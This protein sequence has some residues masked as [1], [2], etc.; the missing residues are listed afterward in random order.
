MRRW[1]IRLLLT[2][3][4]YEALILL[5]SQ[6]VGAHYAD[7]AVRREGRNEQYQADYLRRLIGLVAKSD[8]VINAGST[9]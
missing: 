5:R 3:D 9:R 1:L 4:E 7:L 2:G 8:R 6:I